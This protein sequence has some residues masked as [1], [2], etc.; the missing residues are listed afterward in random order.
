V[1]IQARGEDDH[2]AAENLRLRVYQ[3][4]N[5]DEI[6]L[7]APAVELRPGETMLGHSICRPGFAPSKGGRYAVRVSVVD[8]AGNESEPG[9][10]LE[11]ALPDVTGGL[12]GCSAAGV[13]G[14]GLSLLL[15]ALVRGWR[16]RP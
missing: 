7:S 10:V 11:V 3:G 16:R 4:P 2:T 13:G 12:L 9:P 8:E 5:A 6:D 14:P 1:G 15:L